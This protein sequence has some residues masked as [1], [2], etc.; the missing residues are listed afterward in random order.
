M[1]DVAEFPV[2]LARRV[3]TTITGGELQRIAIGLIERGYDHPQLHDLAWEPVTTR[4]EAEWQFDSAAGA[5]GLSLPSR[6]QAVELLVHHH[7]SRISA[8][9]CEPD[10][11]LA[12]MM[13]DAYWPRSPS[14]LPVFMLATLTT[15]RI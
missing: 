11:G 12:L 7:A 8:G 10:E 4:A 2:L 14:T 13:R 5:L 15:C 3:L 1:T 9:Q 6:S